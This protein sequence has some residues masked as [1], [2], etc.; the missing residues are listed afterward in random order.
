MGTILAIDLGKARS[1]FCWY[2][3]EDQ[4]QELKTVASTPAAFHDAL[5]ERAVD[6][7]VIV[8]ALK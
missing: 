7:V 4:T 5:I 1:L 2:Q 6:R 8:M 3:T